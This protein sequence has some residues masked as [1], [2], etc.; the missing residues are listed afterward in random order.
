MV[1]LFVLSGFVPL[2]KVEQ[3][4]TVTLVFNHYLI[5]NFDVIKIKVSYVIKQIWLKY[6]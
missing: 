4:L 3:L 2:I 1:N 5:V 6:L